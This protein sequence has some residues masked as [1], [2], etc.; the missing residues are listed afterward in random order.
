M[1]LA[2]ILLL[3]SC[4]LW[5]QVPVSCGYPI[6]VTVDS[7]INYLDK[8][9]TKKLLEKTG[10]KEI[11]KRKFLYSDSPSIKAKYD[12]AFNKCEDY[13]IERLGKCIYCN[14]IDIDANHFLCGYNF[15][16]E[17]NKATYTPNSNS[18][19]AVRY[20]LQLPNLINKKSYGYK[21]Y[22]NCQYERIEI[23]FKIKTNSDSS[24]TV[25][26]PTNI[27]DC[28]NYPNCDCG[29]VITRDSAIAIV[30][31]IGFIQDN[32][33]IRDMNPDDGINWIIELAEKAGVT[34]SIKINLRTGAQSSLQ[35]GQ[36]I[37]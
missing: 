1:K 15:I 4:S 31:R 33:K 5:G 30:K 10:Q 37:D 19:L 17:T 20:G 2:I 28:K 16:R 32:D 14:Y 24:L 18:V 22:I 26:Y 11:V 23:E 7:L 35:V 29:F 36:R 13:L 9:F 34:K 21:G 8:D 6:H 25:I 27:P 12:S 3:F